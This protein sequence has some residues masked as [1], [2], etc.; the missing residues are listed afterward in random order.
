MTEVKTGKV[1]SRNGRKMS[2]GILDPKIV[3]DMR[4]NK[5]MTCRQIGDH[6]GV[7]HVA[8]S[9]MLDRM[10]TKSIVSI[11]EN[12]DKIINAQIDAQSL[13]VG[14]MADAADLLAIIRQKVEDI[15]DKEAWEK[16]DID[17]YKLL[18][19]SMKEIRAQVDSYQSISDRIY[20]TQAT[21]NFQQVVVEAIEEES[22]ELAE[23]I[24]KRLTRL[25]PVREFIGGSRRTG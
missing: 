7:S 18:I 14:L 25:Q 15:K 21:A 3:A 22:P 8:V 2:G 16:I 10:S 1:I 9:R 23:K 19:E 24:K 20:S 13:I 12:A 4:F 6:F 11:Y 5:G 17:V